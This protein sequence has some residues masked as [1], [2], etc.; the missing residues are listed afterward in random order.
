MR[1]LE[2][3]SKDIRETSSAE[4]VVVPIVRT[5]TKER[6]VYGRHLGWVAAI[7]GS[8]TFA[9]CYL[10]N[11]VFPHVPIML[12]TDQILY[13][14]NGLRI[15]AGQ[16]PYRD[17]F[18]FLPPGTDLIYAL[19][20]RCFGVSLWIPNLLMDVLATIVALLTTLASCR[21]LR[22]AYVVLPA[23]FLL[24]FGLYG[25]LDA[26]HHWFSTVVALAAM[27]VLLH[28][29]EVRHI[30]WAGILCG[31]MA[32]FTQSKGAV[33]T[34]GFVVYLIWWSIQQRESARTRW[35]RCLLLCGSAFV[36]FLLINVH[37]MVK[38]GIVEWCR[39]IVIFPFRYYPTMPGQNWRSP[40]LEFQSHAGL[41]K[42]F[43]AAFLYIA[44]PLTYMSFLWVMRRKR[45]AEPDQ[46]W[47]QLLLIAIIGIAIF[48]A[49][50]PSLSIMRASAVS[51]PATILLAWLLE[52][53]GR[54]LRWVSGAAAA[55][56][57][58][59]ALYL[60]VNT[61]RMHWNYLN[62]PAGR[63]AILDP[64]KYDLYRWMKE[65]THPGQA[66]LGIAP[67]SFPLRLETP[68]P[69]QSPGPWEYYRPEHIGRS[70]GALESNRIPLLVLRSSSQFQNTA[71]YEPEHIRP[72]LEYVGSHYR[73]TKSFSTGDEVWERIADEPPAKH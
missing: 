63:T 70:I 43:C 47:E 51:S 45:R 33:V 48:L 5:S 13:A 27:I 19:L 39:W 9:G 11:F 71:G 46:P 22:G 31:V 57:M 38:L 55:L 8:L 6:H 7:V 29:I 42:W 24:G 56:S 4:R 10:R 50:V 15:V 2:T 25:G 65:H 53:A 14:T 73:R 59:C 35:E 34:L 66:Y 32:S 16:M 64:A 72:F 58:A 1:R 18:E 30:V 62:L 28:G 3:D 60:A 49:V 61:Q 44:V 69:I 12:W 26:T 54:K 67:L 40:M 36:S 68:G 17:Y 21:I 52:H 23:T 37:Y 20:F 41:L